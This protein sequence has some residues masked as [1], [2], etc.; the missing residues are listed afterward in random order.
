MQKF[1]C[2][3]VR[4]GCEQKASSY[5]NQF[6]DGAEA[7]GLERVFYRSVN[8]VRHTEKQQ[9]MKGYIF[10]RLDELP[11][12]NQ[13]HDIPGFVRVLKYQT[14]DWELAGSD[15][16]FAEYVFAS[17]GVLGVSKAYKIGGRIRLVEG[18]LKDYEGSILKLD[19]HRKNG[20]VEISCHGK[21]FQVW[22]PFDIV[23]PV[24]S[25]CDVTKAEH[26]NTDDGG[27][28]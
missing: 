9:L 25:P 6:W 24:D 21:R 22:L 5:I 10:L 20:L 14:G 11:P 15:L 18:P 26:S 1:S 13:L 8:G 17:N 27:T 28:E 2:I 19:R 12:S 23:Q 16:S 4:T 7:T 3:N